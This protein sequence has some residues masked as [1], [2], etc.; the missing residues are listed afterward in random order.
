MYKY[1]TIQKVW[2]FIIFIYY[3]ML[4]YLAIINCLENIIYGP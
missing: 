3:L 2:G 4:K 1:I